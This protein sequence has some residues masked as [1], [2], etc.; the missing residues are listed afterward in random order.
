MNTKMKKMADSR[1]VLSNQN[2]V[3]Q[4]KENEK[5]QKHVESYTNLVECLAN[6]T[7]EEKV[8]PKNEEYEHEQLEEEE[9]L[10]EYIINKK[11]RMNLLVHFGIY[12]H[13]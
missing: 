2:I 13:S 8:N 1:F 5:K 3:E 6:K 10:V 9:R 11:N 4:L 7:T 12:G